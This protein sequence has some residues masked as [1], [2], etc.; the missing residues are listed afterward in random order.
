MIWSVQHVHHQL[1]IWY[2]QHI[3]HQL[4][5]FSD[6]IVSVTTIRSKCH[7]IK[8]PDVLALVLCTSERCTGTGHIRCCGSSAHQSQGLYHQ[9]K[10]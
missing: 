3:H 4:M 9:M 1:M 7:Y 5:M 10:Q 6:H 8:H 2:V